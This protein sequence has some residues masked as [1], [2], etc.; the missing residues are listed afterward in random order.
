MPLVVVN[1][2]LSKEVATI[3]EKVMKA[4]IDKIRTD[5]LPKLPPDVSKSVNYN[6]TEE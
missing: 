4:W 1:I 2:S 5:V 3:D 6:F